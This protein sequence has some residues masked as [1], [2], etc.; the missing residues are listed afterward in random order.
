MPSSRTKHQYF[1]VCSRVAK[2]L[3]LIACT[4]DHFTVVNHNGA[5][6]HIAVSDRALRLSKRMAHC[7][8]IIH[9]PTVRLLPLRHSVR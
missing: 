7:G 6:R 5:D 2:M 8:Y 3:T 9:I 1:G 4:C